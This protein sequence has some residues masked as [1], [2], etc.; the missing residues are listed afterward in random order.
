[1]KKLTQKDFVLIYHK[2][3]L[4]LE[5]K[6]NGIQAN[7]S[8]L[9]LTEI[10]LSGLDLS[11]AKL[12]NSYLLNM[13]MTDM[14]LSETDISNSILVSC[15][16][17]NSILKRANLSNSHISLAS[18]F[19]VDLSDANLSDAYYYSSVNLI[20]A[21]LINTILTGTGL[22]DPNNIF[23]VTDYYSMIKDKEKWFLEW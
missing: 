6:S 22:D 23:T 9:D 11:K 14:N 5:G 3:Q 1:M 19:E 17:S 4:Y 18:F 20:G 12:S 16:F 8:N 2:H 13:D 10:R 15:N 21:T 7:L